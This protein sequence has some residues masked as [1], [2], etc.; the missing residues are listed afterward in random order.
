[1]CWAICAIP[2]TGLD[3]G[4]PKWSPDGHELYYRGDNGM[5]TARID[6]TDGFAAAT[7]VRLF[8]DPYVTS[9]PR[10]N[11]AEHYAVAPDGRFLMM[12]ALPLAAELIVV[13]NWAEELKQLLPID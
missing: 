8:E 6:T 9:A 11:F 4:P 12:R 5:M 7:V 10:G 13:R 2:P 3:R 1:M